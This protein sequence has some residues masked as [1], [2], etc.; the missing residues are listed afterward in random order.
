MD[1]TGLRLPPC[2]LPRPGEGVR[3]FADAKPVHGTVLGHN[4]SGEA[5]VRNE[6]GTGTSKSYDELRLSDPFTR[7][8]PNWATLPKEG[9]IVEP[10]EDVRSL[11]DG[12]LA[13]QI[14]PGPTYMELVD[15]VWARGFEIYLVGG[16]VRDALTKTTPNDVDFV[17]TMP[18]VR[19]RQFLRSM[20]RAEPSG[21]DDRGFLRI[22]GK[23]SSGDPF[24]DFKV[25]SDSLPGTKEA[26][27]GVGFDRDIKHRDFACNAVYYEPK[28]KVLIDPT[29]FGISDSANRVLRLVCATRDRHQMAQIF[30]RFIKF[31]ERGFTPADET[32]NRVLREYL[33]CLAGMKRDVRIRYLVTQ[34]ASKCTDNPAKQAAIVG[35]KA[36]METLGLS[37]EW[38]LHF[39]TEI[40]TLFCDDG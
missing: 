37:A 20:Y 35:F 18:L 8:P 39:G 38:E 1:V 16:T 6:F 34:V 29:G 40:E 19:A 17:T 11:L 14:P 28:N 36:R 32:L 15:E 31:M 5:L 30:I 9:K 27:F 21:R 7:T 12:L 25:F 2:P 23:P 26:T 10:S 24:I 33:P 3:W 4:A 22:G 13:R